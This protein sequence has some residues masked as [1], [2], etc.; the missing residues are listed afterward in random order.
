MTIS[1]EEIKNDFL[2]FIR[3]EAMRANCT[4]DEVIRIINNKV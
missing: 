4:Q 3:L 2:R 1:T